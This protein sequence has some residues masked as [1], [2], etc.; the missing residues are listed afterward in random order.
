MIDKTGKVLMVQGDKIRWVTPADIA[1]WQN[2]G[3]HQAVPDSPKDEVAAILR[4]RNIS[5][6][7]D[8]PTNN[9][10]IE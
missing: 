2:A 10:E 3:Y 7:Q 6:E 5:T 1:A 8:T 4:P 9:K